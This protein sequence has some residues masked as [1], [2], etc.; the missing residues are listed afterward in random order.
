MEVRWSFVILKDSS[1]NA[2]H[3]MDFG[4]SILMVFYK[5]PTVLDAF[6]CIALFNASN[7]L[8]GIY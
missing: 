6:T 2:P 3:Y 4:L 1:F 5:V 7:S 8:W